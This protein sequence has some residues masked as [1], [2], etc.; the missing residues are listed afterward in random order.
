MTSIYFVPLFNQKEIPTE[1]E[2]K[3][4]FGFQTYEDYS[5]FYSQISIFTNYQI[6]ILEDFFP[7]PFRN[8]LLLSLFLLHLSF[9]NIVIW[10]NGKVLKEKIEDVTKSFLG[11]RTIYGVLKENVEMELEG[12]SLIEKRIIESKMGKLNL[13]DVVEIYHSDDLKSFFEKYE[14]TIKN[15]NEVDIWREKNLFRHYLYHSI[16]EKRILIYPFDQKENI[17]SFLKEQNI[18]HTYF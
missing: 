15:I 5:Q 2:W 6:L 7:K 8:P 13:E 9:Q 16:L 11:N 17:I 18:L 3:V 1:S 10:Q 14:I 4:V 12:Y